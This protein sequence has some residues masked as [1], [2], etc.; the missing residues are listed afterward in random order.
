MWRNE[1]KNENW[2]KDDKVTT[3]D[4]ILEKQGGM[5][6]NGPS[7]AIR[8]QLHSY[9]LKKNADVTSVLKTKNI[10]LPRNSF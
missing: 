8:L 5:N 7:E 1:E 10:R 3:E 2:L 9:M 4:I 6:T